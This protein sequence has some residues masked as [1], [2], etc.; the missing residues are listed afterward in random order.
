MTKTVYLIRHAETEHNKNGNVLSGSSNTQ[1]TI[2]GIQQ[3]K[4]LSKQISIFNINEVYASPL[5]RAYETARLVFPKLNINICKSLSEF[6]YGDYEGLNPEFLKNDPVIK[7]WKTSPGNLE[8]PNG[9][10]IP[11]FAENFVNTILEI[12]E[13]SKNQ[14]IA[15]VSHRTAI[16]LFIAK[17]IN[18]N[19]DYF[20]KLP[21]SNCGITKIIIDDRKFELEYINLIY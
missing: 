4:S 17:V 14:K 12:T 13:K 6:D 2:E 9:D 11:I 3:A 8:F 20:R 5:D 16:R 7:L 21:C 18:L 10:S 1:L 19:L 15:I